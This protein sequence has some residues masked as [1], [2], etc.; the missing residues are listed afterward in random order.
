MS[1]R[2]GASER[3]NCEGSVG[4]DL[5]YF[6]NLPYFLVRCVVVPVMDCVCVCVCVCVRVEYMPKQLTRASRFKEYLLT[7]N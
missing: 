3:V 2:Q 1:V 4:G 5:G 7:A 6:V